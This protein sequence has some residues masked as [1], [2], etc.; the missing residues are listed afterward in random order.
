MDHQDWNT[1]IFKKNIKENNKASTSN[2]REG[3]YKTTKKHVD[4]SVK[5]MNKLDEQ[6]DAGKIEKVSSSISKQ[7]QQARCA[8]SMSQKDL[9]QMCN[10]NSKLIAEY[11]SGKA[12][13]D[14]ALEKKIQN[15]LNVKFKK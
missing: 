14:K 11:E 13:P 12:L 4:S 3:T 7:I 1:V 15:A 9:A 8:R 6:T 2:L 5:K 10:T